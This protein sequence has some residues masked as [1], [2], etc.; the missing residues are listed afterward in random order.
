MTN[1]EYWIEAVE[2]SLDEHGLIATTEQVEKIADDM[3]INAEHQSMVFG[4]D[5]ASENLSQS[6]K[7][8]IDGLKK[9]LRDEQEKVVCPICLGKGRVKHSCG[10]FFSESECFR[11]KGKGR[12]QR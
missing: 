7:N 4:S 9:A 11:C 1:K 10:T 8:E 12:V 5:V 2:S 6:W 3:R